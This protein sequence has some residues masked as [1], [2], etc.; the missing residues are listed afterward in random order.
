MS[1]SV[2]F[3]AELLFIFYILSVFRIDIKIW[4]HLN[5]KNVGFLFYVFPF[6]TETY[7]Y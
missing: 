5:M 1:S 3:F 7:S 4:Y 2:N 6:G